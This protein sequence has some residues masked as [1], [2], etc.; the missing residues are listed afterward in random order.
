LVQSSP[1][2]QASSFPLQLNSSHLRSCFYKE[3]GFF[4][5]FFL[6]HKKRRQRN[7]QNNH[8]PHYIR[9]VSDR[10]EKHIHIKIK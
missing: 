5:L 3:F 6:Q 8:I 10:A 4:C 9:W 1:H 7:E 2:W